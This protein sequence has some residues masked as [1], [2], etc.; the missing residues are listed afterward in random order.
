MTDVGAGRRRPRET[1]AERRERRSAVDDP[2]VVLDAGL[3]F[4]E[5][6]P[7]SVAEVRR[8]LGDAGYRVALI[9]GAVARLLELSLLDDAAFA[10]AWVASRD[11]AHPRGARALRAELFRKGIDASTIADVLAHREASSEISGE[12]DEGSADEA[13]ARQLVERHGR[14]LDRIEDPRK[15]RQR[16]YA[17]LARHGFDPDIA[18]RLSAEGPAE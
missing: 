13:A 10:T 9:E 7:R 8:R 17:L 11:R 1:Y 18:G 16:T 14:A 6:R 2:A 15:R 3:R 5:A 4:L 12:G